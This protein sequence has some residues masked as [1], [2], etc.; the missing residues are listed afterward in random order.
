MSFVIELLARLEDGKFTM[1][2]LSTFIRVGVVLCLHLE[3]EGSETLA[4][5]FILR[6]EYLAAVAGPAFE[7]LAIDV[8]ADF[9]W[10]S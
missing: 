5:P 3:N 2:C 4:A 7:E 1:T 6:D 10:K 8:V 9:L